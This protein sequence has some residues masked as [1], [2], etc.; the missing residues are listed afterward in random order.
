MC[1]LF[2]IDDPLH[3]ATWGSF[4]SRRA[5]AKTKC[6]H[7]CG[8]PRR[9]TACPL[10]SCEFSTKMTQDAWFLHGWLKQN[11]PKFSSQM[12]GFLS[13]FHSQPGPCWMQNDQ[14]LMS[15]FG[16]VRTPWLRVGSP[17]AWL[18]SCRFSGKTQ[19]IPR[20]SYVFIHFWVVSKVFQWYFWATFWLL[21]LLQSFLAQ[22]VMLDS[23]CATSACQEL[24]LTGTT[25]Q[26]EA[27]GLPYFGAFRDTPRW[28]SE[29][30][31]WVDSHQNI[32]SYYSN[33]WF[34]V[35][36]WEAMG[37]IL[38][39][40][41]FSDKPLQCCS[42]GKLRRILCDSGGN[43]WRS[44]RS[45][46][47]WGNQPDSDTPRDVHPQACLCARSKFSQQ[48]GHRFWLLGEASF[49][50]LPDLPNFKG[51]AG[52]W[53]PATLSFPEIQRRLDLDDDENPSV[54]QVGKHEI[55]SVNRSTHANPINV[56][57]LID[58][59]LPC[60]PFGDG[61]YKL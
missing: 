16:G 52:E 39:Y 38:G 12:A 19:R 30:G 5:I 11:D 36:W 1:I 37:W 10:G 33:M 18:R 46:C 20:F 15:P 57:I 17:G 34:Q 42:M 43:D 59:S 47:R 6:G 7:R 9:A 21:N 53:S 14:P 41:A 54:S 49:G 13:P 35:E 2:T 58:I 60:L 8:V 22:L 44:T 25:E 40:T 4:S 56:A 50:V 28:L 24:R 27:L 51:S 23:H 29:W 32:H 26:L 55:D 48:H 45:T 31:I 61:L 3:S